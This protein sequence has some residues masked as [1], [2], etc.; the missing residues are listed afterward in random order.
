M[1]ILTSGIVLLTAVSYATLYFLNKHKNPMW[2]LRWYVLALFSIV[3]SVVSVALMAKSSSFYT[4]KGYAEALNSQVNGLEAEVE[5]VNNIGT[6]IKGTQFQE[7]Y[8]NG[9]IYSFKVP[10]YLVQPDVPEWC[11][12]G[13]RPNLSETVATLEKQ[14]AN[15]KKGFNNAVVIDLQKVLISQ[16]LNEDL[17]SKVADPTQEP[18]LQ[19]LVKALMPTYGAN[20]KH[21]EFNASAPEN[22]SATIKQGAEEPKKNTPEVDRSVQEMLKTITSN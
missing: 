11:Q 18:Y 16:T 7:V 15:F 5:C 1:Y 17:T 21:L 10:V 19:A 4:A 20:K 12:I 6:V 9:L 13:I 22:I 14:K 8:Y 3:A 2:L